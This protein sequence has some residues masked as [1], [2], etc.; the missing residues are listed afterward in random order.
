MAPR[1]GVFRPLVH[2]IP[3]PHWLIVLAATPFA[4]RARLAGRTVAFAQCGSPCWPGWSYG[5]AEQPAGLTWCSTCF[6]GRQNRI[7]QRRQQHSPTSNAGP[8]SGR[9][10][11]P[12]AD[13]SSVASA[14]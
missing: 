10:A 9:P 1:P 14:L 8:Q 2:E 5:T 7:D 6:P 11:V 4:G 12:S 13:T 3:N